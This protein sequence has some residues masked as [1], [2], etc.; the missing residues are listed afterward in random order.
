MQFP[1]PHQDK[2]YTF[3]H[4]PQL[5]RDPTQ[6]YTHAYNLDR[7][8]FWSYCTDGS[9]LQ[10]PDGDQGWS[11]FCISGSR[12]SSSIL[13]RHCQSI[14]STSQ[15]PALNTGLLETESLFCSHFDHESYPGLPKNP[16][17]DN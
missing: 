5:K 15:V 4:F 1:I 8:S 10:Q 16:Q 2:D 12:W 11:S 9:R 7:S 13:Y 14:C 17:R 3:Y 6:Y